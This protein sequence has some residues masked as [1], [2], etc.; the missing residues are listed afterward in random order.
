MNDGHDYIADR[1]KRR[2]AELKL[3]L[4]EIADLTGLSKSTL[5]RY[6]NGQTD[7]IPLNKLNELA[8]ALQV[9]PMYLMG[10]ESKDLPYAYFDSM[11]D[12]VKELGYDIK[13]DEINEAYMIIME[14]DLVCIL[15]DSDLKELKDSVSAFTKFKIME[16]INKVKAIKSKNDA[17]ISDTIVYKKYKLSD[18]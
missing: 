11:M 17:N 6:E 9:T 8:Y 1:I 14:D 5:Q 10:W 16:N 15:W 2:R 3:S 7:K 12:L 4:Q 18:K 13:Y